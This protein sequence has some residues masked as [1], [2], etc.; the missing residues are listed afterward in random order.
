MYCTHVQN[1]AAAYQ[2]YTR[3]SDTLTP[4]HL[5]K[6]ER[7]IADETQ[8]RKIPM[9]RKLHKPKMILPLQRGL[10]IQV[11]AVFSGIVES[12]QNQSIMSTGT[13]TPDNNSLLLRSYR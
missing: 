3:E 11:N 7:N 6:G 2:T 10:H 9:A 5:C 8:V 13:A 12:F 4:L 1:G